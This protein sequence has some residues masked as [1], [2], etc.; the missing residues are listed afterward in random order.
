MHYLLSTT[1]QIIP[2]KSNSYLVPQY[3]SL[4]KVDLA[5]LLTMLIHDSAVSLAIYH[6]EYIGKFAAACEKYFRMWISA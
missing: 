1:Y 2:L 5:V 6:E 4:F 3:L